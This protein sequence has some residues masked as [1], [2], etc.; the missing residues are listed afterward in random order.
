MC[1]TAPVDYKVTYP[2]VINLNDRDIQLV[3][4]VIIAV[5]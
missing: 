4:E 2:E 1:K 5:G 3:K